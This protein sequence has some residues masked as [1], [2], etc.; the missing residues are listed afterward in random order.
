MHE[1]PVRSQ[2]L[3][4]LRDSANLSATSRA[5]GVARSTIRSWAAS[6][7]VPPAGCCRCLGASPSRAAPYAALLGFYL[8]D[9]CISTYRRHTTLRVSCDA[10]LPGLITDVSRTIRLVRAGSKVFHLRAPGVIV[11]QNNWKH[12]PCLFPQHGPGRKHERAIVLQEWQS[13]VVE[14]FPADFLRGLFH[15]DGC[16]VNNWATRVVGGKKKRYD[17]PRWQFVNAS[18]DILG[19]CTWALDLAEVPWRRSG[20]RVVSVS[21]REAVA[22]LDELIGPKA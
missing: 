18:E 17:Y 12:W 2:A 6:S 22:R 21:R 9:G 10:T 1:A 20:A 7:E 4:L 3:Q 13:E 15:S 8:G 19:L 11:V 5:T 14:A 16:R